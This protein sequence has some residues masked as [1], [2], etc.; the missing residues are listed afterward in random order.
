MGSELVVQ[1][2]ARPRFTVYSGLHNRLHNHAAQPLEA[3]RPGD[4]TRLAEPE[5]VTFP[6]AML[7]FIVFLNRYVFGLY[8]RL[9]RGKAIQTVVFENVQQGRTGNNF[10]GAQRFW[11]DPITSLWLKRQIVR[12]S[13][14]RWGDDTEVVKFNSEVV[15]FNP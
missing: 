12:I 10:Q 15:K 4:G 6:I 1:F 13:G 14:G 11:F 3:G 8:F 2:S 7:I 5:P 9:I